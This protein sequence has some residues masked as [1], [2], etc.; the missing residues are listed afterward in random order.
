LPMAATRWTVSAWPA[1]C[2][3]SKRSA[4]TPHRE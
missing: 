2:S 3:P 4:D 1:S